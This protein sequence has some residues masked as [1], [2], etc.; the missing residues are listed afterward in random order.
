[1]TKAGKRGITVPQ[2][3]LNFI[4][5]FRPLVCVSCFDCTAESDFPKENYEQRVLI[6]AS[7]S[8]SGTGTV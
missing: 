7:A 4:G 8:D 5:T 3:A 6:P 2:N 1:M